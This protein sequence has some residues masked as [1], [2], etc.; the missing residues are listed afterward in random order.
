MR[1]GPVRPGFSDRNDG[2]LTAYIINPTEPVTGPIDATGYDIAVYFGPGHSGTVTADI[3]GASHFGVVANG[4]KVNVTG[5]TVHNIGD[6]LVSPHQPAVRD[7]A[8][9]CHLLY[10]RRE[11]HEISGN[12]VYDFQKSGIEVSGGTVD[13]GNVVASPRTSAS[14]SNN[15]VTGAGHTAAI[16]QNGIVIRSGAT[17][18]V[19]KNT[20]SNLWYM[21]DGTEAAGVLLYGAGRV[22][23]QNNKISA[24]NVRVA[25]R[26]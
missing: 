5:S 12:K 22:N 11:R 21:P 17:A 3:S 10:Q 16:A 9:P 8:R 26:R 18:T 7:A 1:P 23:V 4:A 14:V 24:L 2:P 15:I 20:V 25:H 6:Q 19:N 13:G